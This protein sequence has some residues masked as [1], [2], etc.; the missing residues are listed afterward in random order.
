MAQR[1]AE[2]GNCREYHADGKPLAGSDRMTVDQMIAYSAKWP[3]TWH[4]YVG[5]SGHVAWARGG[6][7][8]HWRDLPV[9]LRSNAAHEVLGSAR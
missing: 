3:D 2:I 9:A 5:P 4:E 8:V 7:E 6:R 1:T